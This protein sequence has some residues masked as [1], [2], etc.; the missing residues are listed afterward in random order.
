M[1]DRHGDGVMWVTERVAVTGT[2]KDWCPCGRLVGV[3]W[4]RVEPGLYQG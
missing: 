4:V 2:G 3:M 1:K